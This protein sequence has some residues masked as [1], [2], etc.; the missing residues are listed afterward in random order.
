M[1]YYPSEKY[2]SQMGV[3]FPT[4]WKKQCSKPPTSNGNSIKKCPILGN[5]HEQIGDV[6]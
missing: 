6:D 1:V 2:E 5:P 3:L 4:E